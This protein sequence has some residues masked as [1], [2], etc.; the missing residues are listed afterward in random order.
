MK[1]GGLFP[2]GLRYLRGRAR[3]VVRLVLWSVVET[4][5]TFLMGYALARALDDGFLAGR[6]GWSCA[7]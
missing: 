6:A 2:R 3:V 1:G 5:Q 7:P 4:G